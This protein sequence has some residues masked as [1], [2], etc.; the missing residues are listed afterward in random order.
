MKP[1]PMKPVPLRR[2]GVLLAFA[3][4]FVLSLSVSAILIVNAR[5]ATRNEIDTAYE[6]ATA[7]LDQ[8]RGRLTG[9]QAMEEALNLSRQFDMLRHVHAEVRAPDG[10]LLSAPQGAES[11]GPPGWFLVLLGQ[12]E[13]ETTAYVTNYPNI[14]GRLILRSDMRDEAAEVWQDFRAI[15]AAILAMSG[16]AVLTTFLVL[17]LVQRRLKACN[18]TLDAIRQGDLNSD[19]PP[20]PLREIETLR[21]G[22]HALGSDLGRRRA[23]NR[24]LQQRLMT[25]SESER[26]DVASDLH[27]GL[28]PLLFSLRMSVAT[29]EDMLARAAQAPDGLTAEMA[30]EMAVIRRNVEGVQLILRSIIYRLRP[31]VDAGTSLADVLNDCA[32]AF[33][34]LTPGVCMRL[35]MAP[36]ARVPIGESETLAILRFVQESALNAVRHGGAA[37]IDLNVST[38]PGGLRVEM[39]D[40]GRGP[41]PDRG[42]SHGQAGIQDR[43]EALGGTYER[44]VR[45]GCM[46][47]TALTLPHRDCK[48]AAA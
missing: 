27:D 44:P 8:F 31:M 22:I 3:M 46:T 19:L 42:P 39:R 33:S 47:R 41:D 32:A 12:T 40:D 26:R 45:D 36:V 38:A 18:R 10:K 34:E 14:L 20:Q 48:E 7:Y 43:A 9:P 13:Q 15:L 5:I 2:L 17:H 1:P 6:L 21:R 11:D 35:D 30:A 24:L 29:A 25:L 28:G 37:R 4:S 23:E 16:V